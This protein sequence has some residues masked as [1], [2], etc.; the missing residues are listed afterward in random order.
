MKRFLFTATALFCLVIILTGCSLFENV[1]LPTLDT[2]MIQTYAAGTVS[3]RQTFSALET[4]VAILT[5]QPGVLLTSQVTAQ[6]V[7]ITGAPLL[8]TSTPIPTATTVILPSSTATPLIPSATPTQSI[9]CEWAHFLADV[10]IPDGTS[11]APEAAFTKTWGL[12][13][14][15]TC[16]WTTNYSLVFASGDA[17]G[18]AAEV[19]LPKDVAPGQS[20]DL[21]I[22]L[23]AP[24]NTG[25]YTGYYQIRDPNGVKFGTGTDGKTMFYVKI[26]VANQSLGDLHLSTQLCSAVWKTPAGATACPSNSYDF[27]KGSVMVVAKPKLEGGYT[28][29]EPAIVMVPSDGAGGEI[30]G[31]FPGLVIKSGDHFTALTGLMDGYT[32][33]NVMF[34]LNYSADGAA[35]QNL[36]T[37]SKTYDSKFVRIDIDLSSLAGKNVQF[38]LK[39][40]NNDGS[41]TDDVAFWLIPQIVRP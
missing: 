29:D 27:S 23:V 1:P 37:W 21:S 26:T 15:G 4:V 3:A 39:V 33:G 5:A 17:M 40:L 36:K 41:S 11:I 28:D 24:K 30:S 31:R 25:S 13:N 20:V 22:K 16:T 34:M 6:P 14:K 38:V 32:K 12:L 18:G 9:P 19:A 8:V 7:V 2:N 35:D 10:T